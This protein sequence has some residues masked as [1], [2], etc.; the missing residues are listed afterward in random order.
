MK[1]NLRIK[2]L[3]AVI[4]LLLLLLRASSHNASPAIAQ[5]GG[6]YD[7]TWNMIAG[8]YASVVY[9]SLISKAG[10]QSFYL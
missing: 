5:S 4:V 8:G 3:F 10:P 9:T 6:R 7:L 2:I 1:N